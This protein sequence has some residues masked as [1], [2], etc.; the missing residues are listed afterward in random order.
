MGVVTA[1]VGAP[2]DRRGGMRAGFAVVDVE[3]TGFSA[4]FDRVVELAVVLLD[5][6]GAETGAFST[7]LDPGRPP[8]PT[9]VHGITAAMLEGAPTFGQVHRYLAEMLSGR[10]IVGHNVAGF[11]LPFL[12]AEY[13]RVGRRRSL[14]GVPLLDTLH[15]AQD[16]LDLGGHARLVDCCDRYGLSWGNHHSAL[17]DARVT[18]SLFCAMRSELGD[19][20]LGAAALLTTAAGSVWPGSSGLVPA[21]RGRPK[22]V[23]AV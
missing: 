21:A 16:H 19:E 18:A 3:T 11:D 22:D 12:V 9:H 7:L 2:I 20:C 5:P 14:V 23:V 17:G 8:G 4:A 6:T 1:L 15:L 10:V 13:G